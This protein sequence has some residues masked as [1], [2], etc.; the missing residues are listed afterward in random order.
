MVASAS[1]T[2]SDTHTLGTIT[3]KKTPGYDYKGSAMLKPGATKPYSIKADSY[4]V[5]KV[6][7]QKACIEL[8]QTTDGCQFWTK[9]KGRCFLK[10]NDNPKNSA[11]DVKTATLKDIISGH[12]SGVCTDSAATSAP[13]TAPTGS[14]VATTLP[15]AAPVAGQADE[16]LARTKAK[17]C[18]KTAGCFWARQGTDTV[19]SCSSVDTTDPLVGGCAATLNGCCS[20]GETGANADGSNCPLMAKQCTYV[21]GKDWAGGNLKKIRIGTQSG[22][23]THMEKCQTLCIENSKCRYYTFSKGK[24]YLKDDTARYK[25]KKNHQGGECKMMAV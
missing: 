23:T 16:C 24:C 13:T 7:G 2:S 15:T 18:R 10:A 25:S 21:K 6:K 14:P 8:C 22:T 17:A 9:V 5:Y 3:C 20:D 4:H 1:A 12:K 11:I 19:K